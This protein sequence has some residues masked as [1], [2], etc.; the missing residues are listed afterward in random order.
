VQGEG[1]PL[2]VF[3]GG[4]GFDH[5]F[6]QPWPDTLRK[7]VKLA[8]VDPRGN[9]PSSLVPDSDFTL[10]NMVADLEHVRKAIG[11]EKW[12]VLDHSHGALVAQPYA[13][14]HPGAVSSLLLVDTSGRNQTEESAR[15]AGIP[16]LTANLAG[17]KCQILSTSTSPFKVRGLRATVAVGIRRMTAI[18]R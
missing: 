8:Y 16:G 10:E 5:T 11:C 3:H 15:F 1:L 9:G 13:I 12:A 18:A 6:F 4:L 7:N 17:S 14:D 2:L